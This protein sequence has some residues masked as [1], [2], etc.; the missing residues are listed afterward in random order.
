VTLEEEIA[1]LRTTLQTL[2]NEE[3]DEWKSHMLEALATIVRMWLGEG[4]TE[5]KQRARRAEARLAELEGDHVD[6]VAAVLAEHDPFSSQRCSCGERFP[7]EQT[8]EKAQRH[9]AER[10]LKTLFGSHEGAT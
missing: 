1:A 10:V 2:A 3:K 8:W 5:W 4:M 7:G 9:I 6:A